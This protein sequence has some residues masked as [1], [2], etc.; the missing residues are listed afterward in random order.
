MCEQYSTVRHNTIRTRTGTHSSLC[1]HPI[2]NPMNNNVRTNKVWAIRSTQPLL[3]FQDLRGERER[4]KRKLHNTTA[5]VNYGVI[6]ED[7][8]KVKAG[9]YSACFCDRGCGGAGKGGGG[10]IN[11]DPEGR[12]VRV[13]SCVHICLRIGHH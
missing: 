1:R 8:V 7:G 2:V 12:P 5:A 3:F 11:T 4:E 6:M 13:L 10:L 9:N